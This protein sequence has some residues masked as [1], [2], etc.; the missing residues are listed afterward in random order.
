MPIAPSISDDFD[1]S[2]ID[3]AF[4][5]DDWFAA[6]YDACAQGFNSSSV[7]NGVDNHVSRY[8]QNTV[9]VDNFDSARRLYVAL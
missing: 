3:T 1:A 2:V 9:S 7:A 8:L 4:D 6:E 5:F